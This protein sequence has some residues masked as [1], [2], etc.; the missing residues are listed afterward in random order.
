M[1]KEKQQLEKMV[2]DFDTDGKRLIR[3]ETFNRIDLKVAQIKSAEPVTGADKL[4]KFQMDDGTEN[5]RQVLSAIAEFYPDPQVLVGKKIVIVANLKPRKMRGE[6]S[7]GML[8]SVEKE[9]KL[10]VVT[11]ND[12]LEPGMELG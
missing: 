7:Q 3:I 2:P 4:L 9:G 1:D 12:Q 6:I 5:G 10:H 11:V 8:L